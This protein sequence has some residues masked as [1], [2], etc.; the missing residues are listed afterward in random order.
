M[1]EECQP[2]QEGEPQCVGKNVTGYRRPCK[3]GTRKTQMI[4][5]LSESVR[6]GAGSSSQALSG[7]T[8]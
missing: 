8:T 7:E 3:E 6:L 2:R 4:S 1:A 5:G